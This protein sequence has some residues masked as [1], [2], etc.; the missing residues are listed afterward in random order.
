MFG[1]VEARPNG[2]RKLF[3]VCERDAVALSRL[4]AENID[5]GSTVDH[6]GWA[7]YFNVPWADLGIINHRHVHRGTDRRTM[8]ES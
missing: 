7:G 2:K 1:L 8:V 3:F 5:R 4:I 6:D